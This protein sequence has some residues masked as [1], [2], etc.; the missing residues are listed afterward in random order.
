M[1]PLGLK[2]MILT[3]LGLLERGF[4]TSNKFFIVVRD[5]IIEL[6]SIA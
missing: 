2:N 4:R 6:T 5:E 3:L 1:L